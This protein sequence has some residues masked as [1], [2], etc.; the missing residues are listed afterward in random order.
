MRGLFSQII[1]GVI[2]T[3][4]GTVIADAIIKSKHGRGLF[5]GSQYSGS[6]RSGR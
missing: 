1:I 2:V 5:G 3:V 6:W 4:I